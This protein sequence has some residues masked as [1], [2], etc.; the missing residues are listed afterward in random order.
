MKTSPSLYAIA[1]SIVA[2]GLP[3]VVFSQ[4]GQ[5]AIF[6]KILA[7]QDARKPAYDTGR[8]VWTKTDKHASG[9]VTATK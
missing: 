6:E 1:I 8:F 2:F 7:S 3:N 5:T 9:E 4:E